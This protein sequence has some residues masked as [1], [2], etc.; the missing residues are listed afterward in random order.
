M[1]N[2]NFTK[3][4][5]IMKFTRRAALGA[6]AAIGFASFALMSAGPTLAAQ[7]IKL[8]ISTPAVA[9]DWH[10][11]MLTVFKDEL[12][13]LAPGEFNVEIHLNASLF[14]QGTEPTAMQRGNLEMA[15]ISA[16]D[17]AKQIPAW[18]VF[19]AGYLI[20]DPA[21]QKAVFR[22]DIGQEFYKMVKDKMNIQILDVA[23]RT[24]QLDLRTDKNIQT[25]ADLAGTKLRMPGSAAWQ[26][27]GRALG[28]NPVPMAF[29]EVYTA[30]QSGTIDGQDN[31]LPTDKAA[32]FYEV[33]KQIVLTSHLVDGVFLS[34]AGL[35]WDK[36]SEE[37]K[38]AVNAA[39]RIA[40]AYN[41]KNRIEDE[42]KLVDFFKA[43]GLKVYVPNR[44]AF[45]QRV[46][47]MY[48][49]SEFAKSWPEGIVAR[50]NAVK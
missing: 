12:E 3:G 16:Q 37:Q 47:K 41:D 36:L 24:R 34:M 20:R 10:A 23:Y 48:L 1:K 30:L 29:G 22:G 35:T 25:P 13:K 7:A 17:I 9:S 46:Q 40:T 50:I 31:P 19:T 27:L 49:E 44:D 5:E 33:T 28:A 45:R 21:H 26:F 38:S 6:V 39:A 42:A 11:K 32:K 18:S 15:M 4:E 2:T 8:R 14:K 43:Q